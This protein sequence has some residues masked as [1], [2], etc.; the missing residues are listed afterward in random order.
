M[1]KV[2]TNMSGD[3]E[4]FTRE[5]DPERVSLDMNFHILFSDL[6][7]FIEK[8]LI[9]KRAGF[10]GGVCFLAYP[11]QMNKIKYLSE[12]FKNVGI[13]FAL[14]AFWGEYNGKRYP[15]S[16]TEEEKEI[17]RPF[18]GD[19]NRINYHLNAKSPKGKLC[20]A[21]YKYAGIHANGDVVRCGPLADKVIG[22]ILK[23]N[24]GLLDK[25][26]P[27]E[28]DVCPCNEYINLVE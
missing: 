23:D 7:I 18:L 11:P 12:R 5:I 22:N 26:M 9:L 13:G 19:I 16:Y 6:D 10:D 1:V 25:P 2:T 20:Y 17:M 4:N 14:A 21:G 15:E 28:A 8:V 3:V 24:F 27:C